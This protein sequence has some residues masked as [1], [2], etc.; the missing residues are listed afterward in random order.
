M[1]PS[2]TVAAYINLFNCLP[3]LNH[4]SLQRLTAPNLRFI[5]PFHDVAGHAKVMQVLQH[6][7]AQ[8]KQPHFK[9]THIAWSGSVCLLRWDFSGELPL[10][11]AWNFPGVSE[12]HLDSQGLI[13]LHRD[14]WDAGLYFYQ[15]LPL[16]GRLLHWIRRRIQRSSTPK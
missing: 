16:L 11:G 9:V 15:R 10:I 5:D 13:C 7:A 12:L 4:G 8:V 6:F 2:D 3:Q 14:H 1:N